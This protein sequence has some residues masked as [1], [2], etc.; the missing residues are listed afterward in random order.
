MLDSVSAPTVAALWRL[1]RRQTVQL[2]L[3]LCNARQLRLKFLHDCGDLDSKSLQVAVGWRSLWSGWPLSPSGS[4]ASGPSARASWTGMCSRCARFRSHLRRLLREGPQDN[5]SGY[6]LSSLVVWRARAL[7]LGSFF[8][9]LTTPLK[10][11]ISARELLLKLWWRRRSEGPF[12][13]G[14]APRIAACAAGEPHDRIVAEDR[15][16]RDRRGTLRARR[17]LGGVRHPAP[18]RMLAR[19]RDRRFALTESCDSIGL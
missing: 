4:G 8:R 14:D 5:P 6:R 13:A 3:D 9:R 7:R 15:H 18:A 10:A 2:G 19:M 12:G 17:S 16:C 11:A 1:A